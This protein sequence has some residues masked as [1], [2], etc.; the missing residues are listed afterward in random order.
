VANRRKGQDARAD[1]MRRMPI[2][3]SVVLIDTFYWSRDHRS[4]RSHG[5][6]PFL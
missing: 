1:F 2:I 5:T 3:P 6:Q 4:G